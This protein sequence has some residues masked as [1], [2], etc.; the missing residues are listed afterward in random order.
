[1]D[2][3]PVRVDATLD[4]PLN[5]GLWL[6][7]WLLAIPHFVILFFLWIAFFVVS[8]IAFFAILFTAHYPRA[9]FDF[10]VGVLRWSWRVGYYTYSALGT[11]RYPPFSLAEVPDYPAHLSVDYP[12]R[13]SRG[14]VL[15]KWWLLAIPHYLVVGIFLGGGVWAWNRRGGAPG[16]VE[17][18]VLFAAIVLLFKGR[19]PGGI[20]DLVV[21]MN[22]WALRVAGYAGLM[23]DQYP[24]FRLEQGGPDPSG[25]PVPGLATPGAAPDVATPPVVPGEPEPAPPPPSRGG[26]TA[27]RVV[28]LVVGAVLGLVG[29]G[30]LA[31]GGVLTWVDQTQRDSA[32]YL[33][34][35]ARRLATGSYALS[36][37]E[38][39]LHDA[40]RWVTRD[41][42]GTVK[43]RVAPADQARDVFLGVARRSAADDYLAGVDHEVVTSW[44]NG[45][46][47][48]RE[49][50]GTAPNQAPADAGIWAAQASGSGTQT[51]TWKPVSG[52]WVVVLMNADASPGIAV[53]AAAGARVP[54]LGG[55]AIGLLVAGGVLLAVGVVMV[56]IP[57]AR[58][59]R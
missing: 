15:V 8:I 21:G 27:G 35:D 16:L 10:N 37:R 6:V 33:T 42:I 24:P 57:A 17:L 19:Y 2:G 23:T 43:I 41:V 18:L 45:R 49:H 31:G 34:S 14:L 53:D 12:E 22:R 36:S 26:W 13:L 58:A 11:D 55:V 39:D 47:K 59:S 30:L 38:I 5:R 4:A 51:L 9:L 28:T 7:K 25:T 29:L 56:A 3:Y 1:M 44:L 48:Y 54:H 52:D 20:Y 50:A 32:G 46:T 40:P